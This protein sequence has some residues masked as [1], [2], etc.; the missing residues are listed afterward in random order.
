[1]KKCWALFLILCVSAFQSVWS[2]DFLLRTKTAD[3]SKPVV[4]PPTNVTEHG[5]TAN[6]ERIEGCDAYCVF[7]YT[8]HQ[9]TSKETFTLLEEDFNLIDFGTVENPVW[10]EELYE[11]L[12]NYTTLP[13]WS[14]YG[15]TSYASGMIGGVIYTPYLDVRNDGGKYQVTVSIYGMSG[16]E[17]F[18]HAVGT[19]KQTQSF[20]L[21]HTGLTSQTLT[22]T[23][24]S[25]DTFLHINNTE[26]EMFYLDGMTV[27]QELQPNDKAYVMVDLNEAVASDATSC[28][29]KKLR[30]APDAEVVFYDLYAVSRQYEN[31][32]DSSS[33]YEQVYSDFSDKMKV[34]LKKGTGLDR[35]E[36]NSFCTYCTTEQGICLDLKKDCVV[37]IYDVMGRVILN[38]RLAAG[39]HTVNIPS[40]IYILQAGENRC[41]INI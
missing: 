20:K 38:S 37:Q 23:N 5:F 30:F 16:D 25:Q 27:T 1:M 11:N 9:A 10:G 24:G 39:F 17:I 29:F 41:K 15:Y 4:L 7:V 21:S 33:R 35:V 18:V 19:S 28:N 12:D 34:E 6:W 36:E 13:N 8:E 40:G 14:V 32:D 2:Q 31:P 26:G 3:L 22:F